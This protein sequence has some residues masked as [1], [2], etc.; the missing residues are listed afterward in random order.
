[1]VPEEDHPVIMVSWEET[2]AFC[3][4]LS[5][6]EGRKYRLPTD[7]EWSFAVGI[8]RSEMKTQT[9]QVQAG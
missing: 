7:N 5:T 2:Q 1:M 8:G 3:V 4:W 6:T 9:H